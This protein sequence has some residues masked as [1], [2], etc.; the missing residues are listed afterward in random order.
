M[1]KYLWVLGD[2]EEGVPATFERVYEITEIE[3]ERLVECQAQLIMQR[4]GL[5]NT[6]LIDKWSLEKLSLIHI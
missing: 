1:N 3:T 2:C 4:G 5:C 6:G